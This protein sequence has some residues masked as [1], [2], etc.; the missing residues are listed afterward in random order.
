M[1]TIKA[2]L[3]SYANGQL[4]SSEQV[5]FSAET[6]NTRPVAGATGSF[7]ISEGGSI[8]FVL[9]YTHPL[10]DS[11][12]PLETYVTVTDDSEEIFYGRILSKSDPTFTGQITY[13]AEGALSFLHDGEVPPEERNSSGQ[14]TKRTLTAEAFFRWC[15]ERHNATVS[16]PR[17]QFTVG[18]ITIDKKNE[19]KDYQVTSYIDT[20]SAFD[21]YLRGIYGGY[22]R[23]RRVNGTL[24]IDWLKRFDR[25]D[26]QAIELG[27]NVQSLTSTMSADGI[28]TVLRPVGDN[29]LLL[30][31]ETIDLF[32]AA[33][34]ATMGRII[35]SVT[36]SGADTKA[37]L[38]ELANDYIGRLETVILGETSIKLIDMHYLDGTIPKI[39]IGDRFDNI[40]GNEG[41]EFTVA[42]MDVDFLHCENDSFSFK[43]RKDL[44]SNLNGGLSGGTLSRATSRGARSSGLGLKYYQEFTDEAKLSTKKVSIIA[45]EL[46]IVGENTTV[47][48]H[49]YERMSR[50]LEVEGGIKIDEWPPWEPNHAYLEG[51]KVSVVENN[52]R[53]GY[54]CKQGGSHTSG[55]EW[56]ETEKEY[57]DRQESTAESVT[58]LWGTE[59]I[60]NSH[61][62][63]NVAGNFIVL[64]DFYDDWPLWIRHDDEP[65]NGHW[66]KVG[67]K[68]KHLVGDTYYGYTCIGEHYSINNWETEKVRYW[69]EE[70]GRKAVQL[71]DGASVVQDDLNGHMI[72]VAELAGGVENLNIWQTEFVGTALWTQRDN[73]TG[74]AGQ[75]DVVTDPVTGVKTIVIKSGGGM[76]IRRDNVEYGLYDQDNLTG[77]LLV[78]TINDATWPVWAKNTYYRQGATVMYDGTGYICKEPHVSVNADSWDADELSKWRPV[79]VTQLKG[80]RILVGDS[81]VSGYIGLEDPPTHFYSDPEREHEVT[82][83]S[84]VLYGDI[85]SDK[86][87]YWTGSR[88]TETSKTLGLKLSTMDGI[89]AQKATIIDLNGVTARINNLDANWI[90]SQV[91]SMAQIDGRRIAMTGDIAAGGSLYGQNIYFSGATPRD[92]PWSLKNFIK[93]VQIASAGGSSYK[94]QYKTYND[95]TWQ[96]AGTFNKAVSL[97]GAWSSGTYTVS[98]TAGT[99]S[100]NAPNTT[101]SDPGIGTIA[102]G[103]G[104]TIDIPYDVG[105][106][107]L[108]NGEWRRVGST[109]LAGTVNADVSSLLVNK[110]TVTS[111]GTYTPGT[112]KIGISSIVVNVDTI[113]N[114]KSRFNAASGSYYIE[115]YDNRTGT[116][117][118]GASVTY[119]LATSGS[120]SSTK[121][122]ITNP[123]GTQFSSTPELPVGSLYTD[124]LSAANLSDSWSSNVLT[125]QNANNSAKK[126]TYTVTAT[127]SDVTWYPATSK[128][129][130]VP[131]ANVDGTRRN[132]GATKYSSAVTLD[133]GSWST[134]SRTVKV[135]HGTTEI[136]SEP[137]TVTVSKPTAATV[138]DNDNTD[139]DHADF[140]TSA[141]GAVATRTVYITPGSFK[142]S[143]TRKGKA[144]INIRMDGKTTND[145]LVART[146]I[147]MPAASSATFTRSNSGMPSGQWNVSCT[148]GGVTYTRTAWSGW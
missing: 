46:N 79:T 123:S 117:I 122:I 61:E 145:P 26:P 24:Y 52:V 125:V 139:Q 31:S 114:A 138:D 39:R 90:H 5:V 99:I 105:Y 93:E 130:C 100:G 60:Q 32:P 19:T 141:G 132:T 116:G 84:G 43:N 34:M 147:S 103:T 51:N 44:E 71:V 85:P 77:G 118:S 29:G 42:H 101:L 23:A 98:A 72:T 59:V 76:K 107:G 102:K 30:D 41:T 94:L 38:Q 104:N 108:V 57:W 22:L 67:D 140:V 112:G 88:F 8:Q 126:K 11:L 96:D 21:Q 115:A 40:H 113:G 119:K 80:D 12:V 134:G 45:E 14:Q 73:I 55:A 64:T 133:T 142:T 129:Q 20:R 146:W 35:K 56:D 2:I 6:Q 91:A 28:Y 47:I 13:T 143:G 81:L 74:V 87:Y 49:N 131:Y 50:T 124:G 128:F 7:E 106:K 9:A 135:K 69:R 58:Q 63:A 1:Y 127:G 121:V 4:T 33:K 53:R 37:K 66:Y 92:D 18:S 3:W 75:F 68:V 82:K 110:G 15:I 10:Y 62:I 109:G 48:A 16:D 111:N 137:I 136:L 54:V 36:F 86:V 120:T 89:I 27:V 70:H 95:S 25:L 65:P 144:A 148:V 78:S 97:S 17:R 83:Q